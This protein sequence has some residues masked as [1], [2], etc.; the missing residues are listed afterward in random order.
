MSAYLIKSNFRGLCIV[1]AILLI[2]FF[3]N[4]AVVVLT[5][6]FSVLF[7]S[8]TFSVKCSIHDSTAASIRNWAE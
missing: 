4:R 1:S 8:G 2:L 7:Y 5:Q 3:F 6:C